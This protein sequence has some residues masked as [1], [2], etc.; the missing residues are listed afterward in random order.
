[1]ARRFGSKAHRQAILLVGVNKTGNSR[2][3]KEN[4]PIADRRYKL[5]L[6]MLEVENQ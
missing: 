1:M 5:D 3:Y 4:I 6:E 2:W